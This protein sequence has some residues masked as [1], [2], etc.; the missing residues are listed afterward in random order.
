MKK[1]IGLSL[2]LVW[3]IL[4]S[5]TF[6]YFSP[7]KQEFLSLIISNQKHVKNA[8]LSQITGNFLETKADEKKT[9]ENFTGKNLSSGSETILSGQQTNSVINEN[10]EIKPL[11]WMHLNQNSEEPL[12]SSFSGIDLKKVSVSP[13]DDIFQLLGYTS[14]IIYQVSWKDIYIK[15]LKSVDYDQ[16]KNNINQLIQQIWGNVKSLNLYGDKQS[17]VNIDVYYGKVVIM[18]I[19]YKG[20]NYLVIMPYG[21][22]KENRDY[23]KKVLFAK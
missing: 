13:Y 8:S 1:Y 7:K 5:Y 20:N 4:L 11:T 3:L 16:E 15:K 14:G 12:L 6:F 9:S 19:S 2:Y 18:L 10:L 22:Y 23:L 17:F 21:V